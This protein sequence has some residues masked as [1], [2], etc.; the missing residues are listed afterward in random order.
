[1]FNPIIAML[2]D[3]MCVLAGELYDALQH[4]EVMLPGKQVG[5]DM[6]A[7]DDVLDRMRVLDHAMIKASK[8]R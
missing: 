5:Q 4:T 1:M 6:G 7:V 2:Y 8:S 3:K